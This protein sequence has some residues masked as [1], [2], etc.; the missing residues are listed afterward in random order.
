MGSGCHRVRFHHPLDY[1]IST[2][3][4]TFP[5]ALAMDLVELCRRC[6]D[7]SHW[8][9][10]LSPAEQATSSNAI[11]RG[12]MGLR[13][14]TR[15]DLRESSAVTVILELIVVSSIAQSTKI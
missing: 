7:H 11:R 1:G 15:I 5:R 4:D 10:D 2:K 8:Q 6:P 9:V 3:L 12:S 14:N 13:L